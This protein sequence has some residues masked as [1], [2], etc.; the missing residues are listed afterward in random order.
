MGVTNYTVD[1]HRIIDE[2]MA[3]KDRY[4]T[5]FISDKATS[6]NVYPTGDEPMWIYA[7]LELNWDTADKNRDRYR[8]SECGK[9]FESPF[10]YCPICGEKMH[11][12]K[13][14]EV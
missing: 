12:V 14:M 5:I 2:A 10:P 8:C 13:K 9:I 11:G 7:P 4:V 1:I 3:K 6:V